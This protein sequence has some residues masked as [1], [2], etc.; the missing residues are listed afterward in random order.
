MDYFKLSKHQVVEENIVYTAMQ[1]YTMM[2]K[3]IYIDELFQR[4]AKDN[5]VQLSIGVEKTL[6]L[7]LTFLFGL[8]KIQVIN[9]MLER[10]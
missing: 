9:N 3:S 7:A 1:V 8:G 2:D 6:F 10:C 5:A 4:Y